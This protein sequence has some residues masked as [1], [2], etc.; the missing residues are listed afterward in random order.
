MRRLLIALVL[1][2]VLVVASGCGSTSDTAQPESEPLTQEPRATSEVEAPSPPAQQE[3]PAVSPDPTP[4]E[5]E[6][7][8]EPAPSPPAEPEPTG[9][10]EQAAPA[11]DPS[12]DPAPTVHGL[13]L[14]GS[15]VALADF[16]GTPVFVN[17][18]ASW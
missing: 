1:L 5:D 15:E 4:N 16:L 12:R 18:W 7:T 11:P 17:V 2:P 14:D 6:A 3:K 8:E 9:E 13:T 10:T